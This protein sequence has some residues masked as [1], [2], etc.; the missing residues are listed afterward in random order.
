MKLYHYSNKK[1]DI[2]KIEYFGIHQYSKNDLQYPIKR[3]FF[4][5]SDIPKEYHLKGC[6]YQYT[7]DIKDKYIYNL[8][9][10]ILDLKSRFKYD[11][12]DILDYIA[13]NYKGCKYTTSYACYCIFKDVKPIERHE[14]IN[15]EYQPI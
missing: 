11:I 2:L 8:D 14:Y 4:Y 7:I 9:N 15:Q 12:N 6:Q 1:M 10:D 13:K 3:L 5:G